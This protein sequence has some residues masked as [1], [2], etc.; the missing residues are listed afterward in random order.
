MPVGRPFPAGVSGNPGGRPKTV[1]EVQDHASKVTIEAVDRT[2]EVMRLATDPNV[3]R[4]AARDLLDRACGRPTQPI[5][6]GE[7]RPLEQEFP[8][9]LAAL[10]RLNDPNAPELPVEP[11]PAAA[12][13]PPPPEGGQT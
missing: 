6:G 5:T 7:G 2:V 9:L 1:R 3:V 10:Q 13:D 4:Q 11:P 12:A 8:G